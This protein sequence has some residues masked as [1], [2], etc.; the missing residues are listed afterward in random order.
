MDN[1][2]GADTGWVLISTALVMLMTPGLAFFYSGLVER[3][4]VL[5]TLLMSFAALG[6]VTLSWTIVGYS[7][8]FAEGSAWVGGF[9][10][11]F[12]SQVGVNALDGGSIPH[13]LF[14]A[15]DALRHSR[16]ARSLPLI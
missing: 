13:L 14:F 10:Y 4:S 7:L 9:D 5:N 1:I 8:A 3:K 16:N 12:L 2:S 15:F 6:V 11:I